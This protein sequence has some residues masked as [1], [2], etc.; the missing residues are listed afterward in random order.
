MSQFPSVRLAIVGCGLWGRNITRCALRFSEQIVLADKNLKRAQAL[1]E[2]FGCQVAHFEDICAN[3]NIDGIAI[4]STPEAHDSLAISALNAGKH[5]FIEKPMALSVAAARSILD[6]ANKAGKQVMVGHLLRY[7]PAF[8]ELQKQ[9]ESGLIGTLRHIQANRLNMGR[10]RAN[11]SALFD[12]CPHDL[13]LILALTKQTPTSVSCH[14]ASFMSAGYCDMI[15]TGLGFENGVAAQMHTSWLS[16]IKE[17]RFIVTGTKGAI[18]FDDTKDWPEKLILFSDQIEKKDGDFTISRSAPL[19][20]LIE[21]DE[22]LSCEMRAFAKLCADGL[23]APTD[24]DEALQVQKVLDQ[25]VSQFT[26]LSH[27]KTK[28]ILG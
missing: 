3:P 19:P 26:F 14:G 12:L 6:A 15:A 23:P 25:M 27:G 17:H 2:E 21:V 13:S 24:G 8:I 11:Q 18:V 28:H 9:L 1:A 10:I 20:L 5:V 4:V 7:H 22:P 16:P